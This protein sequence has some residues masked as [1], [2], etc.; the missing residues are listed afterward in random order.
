MIE[1]SLEIIRK[2]TGVTVLVYTDPS[3]AKQRTG[4]LFEDVSRTLYY[5]GGEYYFFH[6]D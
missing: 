4:A 6:V 2:D 3:R 5:S 1:F